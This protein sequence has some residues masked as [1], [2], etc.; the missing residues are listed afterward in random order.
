[1][2]VVDLS[3]GFQ[4]VVQA[5]M[6]WVACTACEVCKEC[7]NTDRRV[8]NAAMLLDSVLQLCR[9]GTL[10]NVVTVSLH[11]MKFTHSPRQCLMLCSCAA[12]PSYNCI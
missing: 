3:G 5:G 1:V 4:Q 7:V 12:H 2:L 9:C 10:I 8:W 6:C 11:S